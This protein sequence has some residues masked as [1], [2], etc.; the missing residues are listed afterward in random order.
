MGK[1]KPQNQSWEEGIIGNMKE[2]PLADPRAQALNEKL[3]KAALFMETDQQELC[4]RLYVQYIAGVVIPET[5]WQDTGWANKVGRNLNTRDGLSRNGVGFWQ[6]LQQA[7]PGFFSVEELEWL[8]EKDSQG[9]GGGVLLFYMSLPKKCF[10]Y[11][12]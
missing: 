9:G 10:I 8:V 1:E 2:H 7:I 12:G 3:V 11:K 5:W 6:E 4:T